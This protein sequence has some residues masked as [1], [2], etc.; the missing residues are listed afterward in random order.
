MTDLQ[1]GPSRHT[2]RSRPAEESK[3]QKES[4]EEQL[5]KNT[6]DCLI[7]CSRVRSAQAIWNCQAC[8]HIFHLRCVAEW[9][10]TSQSADAG[11]WRCPACQGESG[12]LPKDYFCFCG[13]QKN[14]P[15][16]NMSLPHSCTDLCQKARSC[17]HRC[18]SLC[19]PG[20]CPPCGASVYKSCQCGRTSKQVKCNSKVVL[21]CDQPCGRTLAC[22]EHRCSAVCH[23][24]ECDP[25][26]IAKEAK[27]FCGRSTKP[28]LCAMPD[29]YSCEQPCKLTM[30]CGN[31]QCAKPC[32]RQ[33]ECSD[34]ALSLV[35]SCPCGRT[36]L[37]KD[38]N[39]SK[40]VPLCGATCQRR[41]EGCEHLCEHQCHEGK[42]PPCPAPVKGRRCRCGGLVEEAQCGETVLVCRRRCNK[43]K[44]CG[45]H[46]CLDECCDKEFH[47]CE[48]VCG[49]KLSCGL[50]SC[51][52]PC[53][54]GTCPKCDNVSFDELRCNCGYSV[55][56]PPVACNAPPPECSQL[57]GRIHRCT[58]PVTHPCHS[59]P[60]CPP[61]TSLIEKK[62]HGGHEIRR[63]IP[64]HLD[65]VSC[66]RPCGRPLTCGRHTCDKTCHAGECPTVCEQPC[67]KLRK[68][69]HPC[70]LPC[71]DECPI[72]TCFSQVEVSCAC[73]RMVEPRT[74][75]EFQQAVSNMIQQKMRRRE[76]VN[77]AKDLS[78][79]SKGF[80]KCVERCAQEERSR[81]MAE[82]LKIDPDVPVFT[83][84]LYSDFVKEEALKNWHFA[85]KIVAKLNDLVELA[86][87]SSQTSR[88]YGFEP[89]PREQRRFIYELLEVYRC[90]GQSYDQEPKRNIVVTAY[91]CVC[92]CEVVFSM[93]PI[94]ELRLSGNY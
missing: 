46:K 78:E 4:M 20:R 43:K 57:C 91:R 84:A 25:C 13:K 45:R 9:A 86:K 24:G 50:H 61:C 11:T 85:S 38:W 56:Y 72:S 60:T 16:S 1:G 66:G 53:H 82:A 79:L 93:L 37:P 41:L 12:D 63:N 40:P 2:V 92:V 67:R 3:A 39:C 36:P 70:K 76:E 44:T 54:K 88:S 33:G 6:Y 8:F 52:L 22:G 89:M 94:F 77:L 87:N 65:N 49:K 81:R 31:H 58:H 21:R 73:G 48:L 75:H 80:L 47:I 90:T 74:C 68:C 42:C 64:C 23:A 62:C 27:C 28:V 51:V 17:P 83:L 15:P 10:L 18:N 59:D 55:V 29:E 14:P 71:H 69:G 5:L 30:A 19:H 35:T 32:H 7:C 26:E 34:C